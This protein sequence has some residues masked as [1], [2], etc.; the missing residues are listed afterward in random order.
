MGSLARSLPH[1]I[2]QAAGES[3]RKKLK[4]DEEHVIL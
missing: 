3:C 2:V 4:K 1:R